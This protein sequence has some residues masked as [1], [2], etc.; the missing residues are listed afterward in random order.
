MTVRFW[1]QEIIF[2]NIQGIILKPKFLG[3]TFFVDQIYI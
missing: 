2:D 3:R 1:Q